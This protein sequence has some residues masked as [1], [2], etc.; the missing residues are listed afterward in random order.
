MKT[1]NVII[2]L[3]LAGITVLGILYYNKCK[4]VNQNQSVSELL[5]TAKAKCS[6]AEELC[7]TTLN[8]CGRDIGQDSLW[9]AQELIRGR[10]NVF[11]VVYG[12][13]IDLKYI[14]QMYKA[15]HLFNGDSSAHN[16]NPIQGIR[17][18]E[19]VSRRKI[20]NEMKRE[21]DLVMVPY[22]KSCKDIYLVDNKML[23]K[24]GVKIYSHFRPCPRLCG[25]ESFYI[26]Q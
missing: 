3:L 23:T 12:Y 19:A 17:I 18:Y 4:E 2:V 9:Y 7:S 22:L 11:N 15:I 14:D 20:N 25:D 26:H 8:E 21:P 24:Y 10:R 13:Q 16:N 6:T 1:K 5:Y